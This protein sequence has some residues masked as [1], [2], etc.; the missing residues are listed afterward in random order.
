MQQIKTV[1]E[2]TGAAVSLDPKLGRL[3]I[4]GE[5][6]LVVR[7]ARCFTSDAGSRRWNI[8]FEHELAWD[9]LVIG[10]MDYDNGGILDLYVFPRS[11]KWPSRMRLREANEFSIDCYRFGDLDA[12][13]RLLQLTTFAEAT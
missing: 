2:R 5:L 8:V 4:N 6:G 13:L 11:A 9:F 10:R 1:A 12:V 7:A 3:T